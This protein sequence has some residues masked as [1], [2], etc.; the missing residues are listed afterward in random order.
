VSRAAVSPDGNDHRVPSR[1]SSRRTSSGRPR[2]GS[3]RRAAASGKY[4]GFSGRDFN[5]AA[6]A[7][8]RDWT[9]ART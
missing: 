5:E 8:S 9:D 6:L 4:P 2:S 3:G 1:S 7:F